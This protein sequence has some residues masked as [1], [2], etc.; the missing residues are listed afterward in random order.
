MSDLI[1]PDENDTYDREVFMQKHYPAPPPTGRLIV[2]RDG[3]S[4]TRQIP[5]PIVLIDT[6]E[7]YPFDFIT[8]PILDSGRCII[9]AKIL[10][11]FSSCSL[12]EIC[13]KS[14]SW[15]NI[16]ECKHHHSGI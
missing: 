7:Q 12:S 14:G 3:H 6:R 8:F 11:G 16:D 5:K 15:G 4:I 1:E 10:F 13:I 2:K 9:S